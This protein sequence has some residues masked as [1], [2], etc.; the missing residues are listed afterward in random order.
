MPTVAC[1]LLAVLEHLV[2]GWQ[3]EPRDPNCENCDGIA[4]T[5]TELGLHFSAE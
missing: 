2:S 3:P 4:G 1:A 5:A